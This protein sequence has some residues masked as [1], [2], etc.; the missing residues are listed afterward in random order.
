VSRTSRARSPP[1]GGIRGTFAS[2]GVCAHARTPRTGGERESGVSLEMT[3]DERTTFGAVLRRLRSAAGLIQ[4]E[5]AER[6][7]LSRR[8]INDLE[9]GA[10]LLPRKDTVALLAA[11]LPRG[12]CQ[13]PH[14]GCASRDRV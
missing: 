11:A 2:Q 7:G 6:A 10:H 13:C 9:R 4:E 3:A 12:A 5:L 1:A 8:G 14:T